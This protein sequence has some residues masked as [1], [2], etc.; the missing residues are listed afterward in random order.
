VA[1]RVPGPSSSEALARVLPAT[2]PAPVAE[3]PAALPPAA[4]VPTPAP[5]Q[6]ASL[7]AAPPPPAAPAAV[8]GDGAPRSYGE[9]VEG[10]IV[11]RATS[12]SWTQVRDAAGNVIFSRILR[13]GESYNAPDREGLTMSTGNAGGLDIRVDGKAAPAVGRLGFVQRSVSLDPQRLIA[14]TAANESVPARP[15]APAAVPAA[16]AEAG[17]DR[18]SPG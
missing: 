16:P 6:T 8:P 9:P 10:R 17:E 13:A 11:I 4:F 5:A 14:G 12:D 2:P 1:P 18:G 3:P 7:P 15:A